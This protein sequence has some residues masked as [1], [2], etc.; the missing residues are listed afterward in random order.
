MIQ[1]DFGSGGHGNFEVVAIE[2]HTLV[3]YFHD[4]SDVN[5]PWQRG[6]NIS[7][8]ATGPGDII[9]SD[10][11]SGGHGNFEVVVPEEQALVHYFHDNPDVNKPW[12]RGQT[13]STSVTG[14]ASLIQSNFGGGGHSFRAILAVRITAISKW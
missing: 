9:Q 14:P 4:N 3:H 1:S 13:I 11:K 8:Q 7:T 2:N 6:Q 12:Q 5:K 10:F